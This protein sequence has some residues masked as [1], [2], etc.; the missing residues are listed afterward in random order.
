[1]SPTEGSVLSQYYRGQQQGRRI[2]GYEGNVSDM[3]TTAPD[4]RP[5]YVDDY[6]NMYY[7]D[8][9]ERV[10]PVA[11]VPT[12]AAYPPDYFNPPTAPVND[13]GT[14]TVIPEDLSQPMVGPNSAYGPYYEFGPFG[15]YDTR[16][17]N[18]SRH[19]D[20]PNNRQ[21]PEVEPYEKVRP[22]QTITND[23][24]RQMMQDSAALRYLNEELYAKTGQSY[25]TLQ[26]AQRAKEAEA[27]LAAEPDDYDRATGLQD[28]TE[29]RTVSKEQQAAYEQFMA[30]LDARSRAAEAEAAAG[31]RTAAAEAELAADSDRNRATGLPSLEEMEA[32]MQAEELIKQRADQ[33]PVVQEDPYQPQDNEPQVFPYPVLPEPTQSAGYLRSTGEG[34]YGAQAYY[35]E[36]N[37][38]LANHSQ[39]EIQQAMGTYGV[40]QEDVDA[41]KAYQAPQAPQPQYARG[42]LSRMLKKVIRKV[43]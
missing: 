2:P 28:P 43:R 25:N 35:D 12:S 39:D 17:I 3:R 30:E 7:M 13:Y 21:V 31:E 5:A 42:G 27:E 14:G 20:N 8:T 26:E 37:A 9:G 22:E 10:Q 19:P 36:I 29:I 41:A 24:M 32:R 34:G 38:Y 11:P 40:S 15:P 16:D 4:G 18:D 23:E 1:M 33:R 6:G